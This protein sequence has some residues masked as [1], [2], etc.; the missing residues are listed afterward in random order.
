M[1]KLIALLSSLAV[2]ASVYSQSVTL[3][4]EWD[5]AAKINTATTDQDFIVQDGSVAMTG[6]LV[7]D[8]DTELT[9][10]TTQTQGGGL[11]LT[12]Q[13]NDITTVANANDAVVLAGFTKGSKQ[14][15]YNN[16]AN[17]LQVFPASGDDLGA[18]LNT[19]T[20]VDVGQVLV[21]TGVDTTNA[22][23]V[24]SVSD[25]PTFTGTLS[26]L[27]QAEANAPDVDGYGQIWVKTATPNEL[28][29]TNDAG[30]D[31]QLGVGG[32]GSGPVIEERSTSETDI[33]N[34]TSETTLYSYTIGAGDL[35]TDKTVEL[36]IYGDILQNNGSQSFV[37]R[38]KLGATTL[39]EDTSSAVS[40]SA[41]RYPF[42]M[43]VRVSALGST[44]SQWMSGEVMVPSPSATTGLGD[45]NTDEGRIF[46]AIANSATEDSTGSLAL[47]V[48]IQWTNAST[49]QSFRKKYAQAVLH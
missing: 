47:A 27:E 3:D 4:S 34:T 25:S 21:A 14:T 33:T 32:G 6:S 17:I 19:S 15:V 41:T 8:L 10:G 30:T 40:N 16:G 22:N 49:L 37:L 2:A 13:I 36:S 44:S 5:T 29:F 39:Y 45:A 28:W 1:K 48:T 18:G 20:T 23:T 35:S 42:S 11:A 43:K 7:S 38:V 24:V 26:L 46:A 12:A 31:V 9:A